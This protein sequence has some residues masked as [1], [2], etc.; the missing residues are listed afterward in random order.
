[1]KALISRTAG[2]PD[3]LVIKNL[4]SPTPGPGQVVVQVRA[5][6]I[7]FPDL[8]IIEATLP[9]PEREGPRGHLTPGE[10]GEHGA[11]ARVGRLVITHI[12]DELDEEWAHEEA[13]KAYGADVEVAAEGATYEVGSRPRSSFAVRVGW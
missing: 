9:R 4:P 1:M 11:R 12:S 6:G 7:N 8:L 10:A 13:A 2:G 3:S 5:C